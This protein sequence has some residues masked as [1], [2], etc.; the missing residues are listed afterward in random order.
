MSV[1]HEE[2]IPVPTAN[3]GFGNFTPRW[4]TQSLPGIG[5]QLLTRP[6]CGRY[7]FKTGVGGV[8]VV[9]NIFALALALTPLEL[10]PVPPAPLQALNINTVVTSDNFFRFIFI[11][12]T[13]MFFIKSITY[14]IILT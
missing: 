2:D 3:L 14:T 8:E 9:A 7:T 13:P 12:Y 10:E 4:S 1:I 11:L 6:V 5:T